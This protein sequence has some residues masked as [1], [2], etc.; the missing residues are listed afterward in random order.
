MPSYV[1]SSSFF[2]F[3]GWFHELDLWIITRPSDLH[4]VRHMAWCGQ[5]AFGEARPVGAS[6]LSL[7][8]DS[9]AY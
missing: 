2:L 5:L 6:S 1:R 3:L 9:P 4:E 7:L 8:V